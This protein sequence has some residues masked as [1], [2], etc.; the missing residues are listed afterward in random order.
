[1]STTTAESVVGS[2]SLLIFERVKNVRGAYLDRDVGDAAVE[3]DYRR[4]DFLGE[5]GHVDGDVGWVGEVVPERD[6]PTPRPRNMRF[7]DDG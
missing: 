2:G 3:V 1:M 7:V 5:P 4:R 6:L